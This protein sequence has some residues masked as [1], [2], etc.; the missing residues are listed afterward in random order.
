MKR[1]LRLAPLAAILAC[2]SNPSVIPSGDFS[3]P[4]GLA[5][6]PLPDR[7]LLFV[8]NQGANELR[9]IILCNAPPN[10]TTTCTANED[11]QFLPGPIRLLAGS[12]LVGER[13]LRL[14]G[15]PLL[16][17]AGVKHGAVLVAGSESAVH[18]VDAANL[19]AASRDKT[20]PFA[21]PRDDART[22]ML[23][24]PPVDVVAA[25][26]PGSTVT[27]VVATEA[28]AGGSA[29]LTVLTVSLDAGGLAHAEPTQQCA[30][31]FVPMRLALIPGK[32]ATPGVPQDDLDANGNPK[33]VY[34][35]DG[36][37]GGT[38]GGQGDGAV[39]VSIPDVPACAPAGCVPS[40]GAG[41]IPACTVT[42]RLPASDPADSPRRARPLLSLALSP[43]FIDANSVRSPAGLF[44]LGVTAPDAAL[45]ANHPTHTCDPALD[46]QAGSVC[47]DHGER[48][49]GAGRIVL[50]G[51]DPASGQSLVLPAPPAGLPDPLVPPFTSGLPPMAPLRAQAPAREVAFMARDTCPSPPP[52]AN[53]APPCTVLQVGVGT[54][55]T[56]SGRGVAISRQVIG[57]ATT[58]DG[59]TVFIDVLKRRF[60]DDLRD[61]SVFG[62]PSVFTQNLT[63]QPPPGVPATQFTLAS[64]AV[65]IGKQFDGWTNPG[66]TRTA[67][68][69]IAW[70]VA[71]PGLESIGGNLSRAAGG[72]IRLTLPP[73]KDLTRWTSSPELQL[74]APS[75]CTVPYPDCFGDFVR[76]LS[77]S[78]TANCA[79]LAVV[80]LSVNIPIAAVHPD[81]LDLQPVPGFDPDPACFASGNVGGTFEVHVGST[82][83]GAWLVL[84]DLDVLGRVAHGALFVT[85]GPRFDYPLDTY[86]P[87]T[88][89][90]P[91][92]FAFVFSLTGPE[93]TATGTNFD[94]QFGTAQAI[95]LVKD[96]TTAGTPGF[97]GPILV[98]DTPASP[99]QV[100]FV[101]ITG[102]NSLLQ[103]IPGQFG[104][105]NGVRF[106]Y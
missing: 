69:R 91:D 41:T 19:F 21:D 17:G 24:A 58:E 34:V 46:V 73:D 70:H 79:D 27:A 5:I 77:Y 3:G 35:A 93:P 9:A 45:C 96:Q 83:A 86:S 8:A 64:P 60:F 18:V 2:G 53:H 92:D 59:S 26:T 97:A 25:E 44:V 78:A 100:T 37:P 42:R 65:G 15:V 76:V 94:V 38:P 10:T 48:N 40:I 88:P 56:N 71:M 99:D 31:D 30:I 61:T 82:T 106:F 72:P 51:N 20:V 95:S 4:T 14:A 102:S 12:I 32:L 55:T 98:Y 104:Q 33:H 103:A 36:T 67:H 87:T 29:A 89:A 49:C 13:P 57:M 85:T 1:L 81:G 7:D 11:R 54:S 75:A 6:A 28:P 47:V 62:V 22:V 43:A 63:P 80:P 101:A 50:L 23:P 16:D 84:E 90:R 68:W 39:E 52:D 74:G 66:V 105:V